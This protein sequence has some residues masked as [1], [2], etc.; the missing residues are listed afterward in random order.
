MSGSIPGTAKQV[1]AIWFYGSCC[2]LNSVFTHIFKMV[3]ILIVLL[4]S[5]RFRT[6]LNLTRNIKFSH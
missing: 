1:P 3:L 6:L 4:M 5:A 2:F